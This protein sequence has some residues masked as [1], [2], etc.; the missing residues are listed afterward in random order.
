MIISM[1]D[2]SGSEKC[3]LLWKIV[4]SAYALDHLGGGKW[5]AMAYY[6]DHLTLLSSVLSLDKVLG[7]LC[8]VNFCIYP[9]HISCEAGVNGVTE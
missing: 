3:H 5:L 7:P 8:Y 4:F 6:L 9:F 1:S 2:L